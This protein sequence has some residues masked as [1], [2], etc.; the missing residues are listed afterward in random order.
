M[1]GDF[2]ALKREAT[3]WVVRITSGTATA[4]DADALM[5]WRARSPAHEQA[6]REAARLWKNLG[7]V[8]GQKSKSSSA[9]LTRRAFL[10]TGSL[11]AGA[12][13]VGF[14]LS[15]LGFLPTLEA[16]LSDYTTGVGEQRTV[17][18]P[19]G[20]TAM[21]DGGTTLSLDFTQQARNLRLTS[22]AA[23]FDVV[24]EDRRPFVVK[25]QDGSSAAASGSFSVT[26][27]VDSVSVDCLK[28]GVRVECL[29]TADLVE[30]EGISY[31]SRG[32]GEKVASDV[33]TA[34]SWRKGLLIFKNRPLG[35]VVSD[36]NRHRKG[37]VVI[38]RR[39]LRSRRVSGVFHLAR[40][41][42]ILAHLEDTLHVRPINL[43]GGV[44]LLQ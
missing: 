19:D 24:A 39:D 27:G 9:V 43:V 23:V 34:A 25:A 42:E 5:R 21:L 36:L 41:E 44:M 33:E 15:Q 32:L 20:S 38:A 4:D 7:P 11:A 30:G 14:G 40:P 17:Q 26:H 10:T 29:G 22:G 1:D 12:A 18:L 3:A 37:K 2:E 8:L 31:S 6:F 16:L 35:D 28:D 13:G